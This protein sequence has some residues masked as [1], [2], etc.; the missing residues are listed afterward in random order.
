MDETTDFHFLGAIIVHGR[1][2]NPSDP[3]IFDV[4]DGQQRITTL[5]IYLCAVIRT[6]C[7]HGEHHEA[8]ALFLKYLVINRD[9]GALSNF[10]L[11]S[12]KDDRTQLNQVFL[13]ILSDTKLKEILGGF[14][15]ALLPKTG[16][17]KG[18][19]SK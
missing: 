7:S 14:K 10:K 17:E 4:I 12:C 18:G 5:F 8:A 3:D 2:S 1:R 6:L 15:L 19:T 16:R 9:T 13:D 11:H